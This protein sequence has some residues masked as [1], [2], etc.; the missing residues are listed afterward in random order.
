MNAYSVC[1]RMFVH[2]R[3]LRNVDTPLFWAWSNE[4]CEY[5]VELPVR[6][7]ALIATF[8]RQPP[9]LGC[10]Q[11]CELGVFVLMGWKVGIVE[12]IGLTI[13]VFPNMLSCFAQCPM[14]CWALCAGTNSFAMTQALHI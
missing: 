1:I 12:A 10:L 7:C 8:V 14:P 5:L 13:L 4:L 2:L 11:A 3:R 9:F 6:C